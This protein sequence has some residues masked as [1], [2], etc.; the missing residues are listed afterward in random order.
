MSACDCSGDA[1]FC[2]HHMQDAF[3]ALEAAMA[4]YPDPISAFGF[5]TDSVLTAVA[6]V[7]HDFEATCDR[8]GVPLDEGAQT[9]FIDGLLFGVLLAARAPKNHAA[10]I[11]AEE[12]P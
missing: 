8:M 10:H 11:L 6:G 5:T 9:M 1:A 3:D 12:T 4:R 7:V 2:M